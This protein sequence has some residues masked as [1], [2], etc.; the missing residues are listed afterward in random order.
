MS[1][2]SI[3][4]GENNFGDCGSCEFADIDKGTYELSETRINGKSYTSVKGLRGQSDLLNPD[5]VET[6]VNG[7]VRPGIEVDLANRAGVRRQGGVA[8]AVAVGERH[9]LLNNPF[10]Q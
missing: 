4:H 5:H 7:E 3:S 10:K 1:E 8:I 6:C 9:C 2:M